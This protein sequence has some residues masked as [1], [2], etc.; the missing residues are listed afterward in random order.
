MRWIASLSCNWHKPFRRNAAKGERTQQ[1]A[2]ATQCTRLRVLNIPHAEG[3]FR[4]FPPVYQ[5]PL[6]VSA[7]FF[8]LARFC[9]SL[10]DS[11]RHE[12]FHP[13]T[14]GIISNRAEYNSVTSNRSRK[15]LPEQPCKTRAVCR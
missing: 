15:A 3:L 6:N 10:R 7:S 14:V 11:E 5:A 8:W 1:N 13:V 2:V 12:F 4:A 9:P